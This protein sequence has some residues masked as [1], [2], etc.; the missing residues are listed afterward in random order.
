MHN[1]LGE[2]A[3]HQQRHAAFAEEWAANLLGP[4]GISLGKLRRI[5][6][7]ATQ[8]VHEKLVQ[9]SDDAQPGG[10]RDTLW[11]KLVRCPPFSGL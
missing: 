9:I 11:Q 1:F 8:L 10:E 6:S 7:V 5:G 3:A 2:E 4:S